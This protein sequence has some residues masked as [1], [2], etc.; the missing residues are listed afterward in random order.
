MVTLSIIRVTTVT[1]HPSPQV[2][3]AMSE[4]GV[5]NPD[6]H[7]SRMVEEFSSEPEHGAREVLSPGYNER[8]VEA[9]DDTAR[10]ASQQSSAMTATSGPSEPAGERGA[11]DLVIWATAASLLVLSLVIS[12]A[13]GGWMWLLAAVMV[14]LLAGWVVLQR[15]M[16]VHD[17][18]AHLRGRKP[19]AAIV[20]ATG[21]AV[22]VFC[23]VVAFAFHH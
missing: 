20:V 17:G 18:Q 13:Q 9:T 8:T 2:A 19:I 7:F 6:E 3:A 14:P 22:A 11:P 12:A 23:A 15:V 4:D 21:A 10:S 5:R 16:T 1:E